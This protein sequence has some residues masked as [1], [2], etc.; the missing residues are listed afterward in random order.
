MS[1]KQKQEILNNLDGQ[2]PELTEE[3]K[4]FLLGYMEGV[5]QRPEEIRKAKEE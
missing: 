1:D 2:V 4:N 5:T 3:Q